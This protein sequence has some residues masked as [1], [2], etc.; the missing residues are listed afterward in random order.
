MKKGYISHIHNETITNDNFRKVLYT[1][2]H[3]QLVVMSLQPNEDIG[4]EIHQ[5]I[6]QFIR[7]E[8]GQGVAVINGTETVLKDIDA[9]VIPAGAEHNIIN[10]G[11]SVMKLYTLYAAPEHKDGII[12]TTKEMANMHHDKEQFDGITT[13]Y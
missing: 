9:I 2:K 1:S 6:D 5:N 7:I 11:N 3:L 4:T 8:S 10:T 13:E 12:Q